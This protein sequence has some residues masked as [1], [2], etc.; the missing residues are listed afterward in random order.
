VNMNKNNRKGKTCPVLWICCCELVIAG[1]P[2][3]L[4]TIQPD[5]ADM[6]VLEKHR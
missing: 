4:D 6:L 5:P 2:P 1:L 3:T